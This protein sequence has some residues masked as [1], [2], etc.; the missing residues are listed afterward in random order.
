M[1]KF[2]YNPISPIARRV[3]I[4][5]LEK[6]IP[7][8][9]VLVNL[10]GDQFQPEFLAINPFHHIPAIVDEGFRVIESLAILDYL[11][12]QYP[13]PKLL[14]AAPKTLATVRMIQMVSINELAP[15]VIALITE[16]ENSP[17]LAKAKQQIA[18]V[19]GFFSSVLGESSY[20]GGDQ[21]TLADIVAGNSVILLSKLGIDLSNSPNIRDWCQRLNLKL[22]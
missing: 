8:E 4:A 12:S 19:L 3:W 22:D 21:F 9:S 17:K 18:R 6:N 11:E 16:N 2:Y 5:L 14:P 10:N 20:F 7:F 15:Q 1:L 13:T